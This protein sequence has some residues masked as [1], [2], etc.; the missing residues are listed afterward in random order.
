MSTCV[1]Y[2][3]RTCCFVSLYRVLL[4]FKAFTQAYGSISS[5]ILLETRSYTLVF[6]SL[7]QI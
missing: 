2:E 7:E 3:L 5:F 6:V 1:H 4:I